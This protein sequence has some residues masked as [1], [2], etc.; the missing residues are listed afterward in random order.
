MVPVDFIEVYLN[1]LP[2]VTTPQ[3]AAV[4]VKRKTLSSDETPAETPTI[5]QSINS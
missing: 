2:A 3:S 5:G 1:L 4:H